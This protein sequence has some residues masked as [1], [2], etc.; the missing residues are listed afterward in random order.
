MKLQDKAE[1]LSIRTFKCPHCGGILGNQTDNILIL[2][3]VKYR[4]LTTPECGYCEKNVR[5]EPR[6]SFKVNK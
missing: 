1:Y 3:A 4:R 2:G 5:W 6:D